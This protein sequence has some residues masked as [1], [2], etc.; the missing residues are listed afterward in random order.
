MGGSALAISEAFHTTLG[1]VEKVFFR[2]TQRWITHS[3][4]L[5]KGGWG[6]GDILAGPSNI[7]KI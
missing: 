7:I 3:L 1:P 6:G 5:R 4:L 2:D